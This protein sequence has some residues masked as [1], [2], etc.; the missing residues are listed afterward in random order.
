MELDSFEK[1]GVIYFEFYASYP[2]CFDQGVNGFGNRF[3]LV[4]NLL[5]K[6]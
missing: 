6:Y 3:C 5:R 2:V 1:D 4:T